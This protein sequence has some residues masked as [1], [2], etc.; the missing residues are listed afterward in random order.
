MNPVAM[1]ALLVAALLLPAVAMQAGRSRGSDR[2]V[3]GPTSLPEA[4][5]AWSSEPAPLTEEELSML[6]SPAACQRVYTDPRSGARVQ[7][8]LLQ[9]RNTQNAHDPKICMRGSGYRLVRSRDE[10]VDWANRTGRPSAVNVAE[11]SNG[12]NRI[13]LVS[14]MQTATDT[15]ADMSAGLKWEGIRRALRG[16][17][18]NGIAVRLVC[19]PSASGGSETAPEAAIGLWRSIDGSLD[20]A[21]LARSL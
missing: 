9:V 18:T 17:P 8:L 1:R 3:V 19:L 10:R 7:V 2:T 13:T 11:F 4:V 16:Q 5:G 21:R 12:Q 20:L 14:W 15:V 6:Q